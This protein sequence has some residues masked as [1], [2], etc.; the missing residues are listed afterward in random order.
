MKMR[1]MAA[2]A[3]AAL[4]SFASAGLAGVDEAKEELKEGITI[5]VETGTDLEIENAR[6]LFDL[7][8]E[9]DVSKWLFTR[10]IL[11][12]EGVV[13]H[14]HPVL[15]LNALP[16]ETE[17]DRLRLLS[18]F[19]HQC[20]QHVVV[21]L[22]EG[23]I[24]QGIGIGEDCRC[25]HIPPHSSHVME[26]HELAGIGGGAEQNIPQVRG[27]FGIDLNGRHDLR[28]RHVRCCLH[29]VWIEGFHEVEGRLV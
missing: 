21:Q 1:L 6:H 4:V 28:E 26:Q 24:G 5:S 27:S 18:T 8:R 16:L 3:G 20:F 14:S 12:E 25:A 29:Q 10:E 7:L 19:I 2:V 22:D 11:I 13:P 15:T 9:Y 23:L 17:L